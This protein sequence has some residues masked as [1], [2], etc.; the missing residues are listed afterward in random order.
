MIAYIYFFIMKYLYLSH[1]QSFLYIFVFFPWLSLILSP[2]TYFMVVFIYN[3]Y[4]FI[5]P[6]LFSL[7]FFLFRILLSPLRCPLFLCHFNFLFQLNRSIY[8]HYFLYSSFHKMLYLFLLRWFQY[9]NT[10]FICHPFIYRASNKVKKRQYFS[11][12]ER[13]IEKNILIPKSISTLELIKG[14]K[15]EKEFFYYINISTLFNLSFDIIFSRL[16]NNVQ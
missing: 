10:Q 12:Y 15:T 9:Q 14:I 4:F 5:L 3:F 16:I 6:L 11:Y 13:I 7:P 8:L 1:F 2:Y